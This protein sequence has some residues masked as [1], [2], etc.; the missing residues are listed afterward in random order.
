MS[1]DLHNLVGDLAA[2]HQD[3]DSIVAELSEEQWRTPTPAEGWTVADQIAHLAFFDSKARL[4]VE[5]P[6]KFA[7]ELA[8]VASDPDAFVEESVRFAREHTGDETLGMWRI[9][10][11]ELISTLASLSPSSRIAWYGPA[12]SPASFI[13]ARIMETWAHGQDIVD[14]L[15]IARRPTERLR[16]IAHLGV[17]AR[18]YSYAA[19]GI[20][21]P[22]DE[23]R[24]ELES[25]NGQT[26][27]WGPEEASEYVKGTA[28]DFCLV[29]TRRR[30]PADTALIAS[31]PSV[32]QWLTIAQA[33]AGPPGL[34]RKP[35]QFR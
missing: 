32:R 2:E 4:A 25:P 17:R 1:V 14:A 33:Y 9:N 5:E 6:E 20:A 26:W 21:M 11:E 22:D 16:H 35:G 24:V 3:L 23:I 29:V 18:P 27:T 31:G 13:S 10:R 30:H 19:H 15:G 28:V 7:G 8:E 12:M 34:G